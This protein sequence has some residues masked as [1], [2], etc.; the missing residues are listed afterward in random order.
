[1]S[2]TQNVVLRVTRSRAFFLVCTLAGAFVSLVAQGAEA[3]PAP[4]S[5]GRFIRALYEVIPGRTSEQVRAV[6]GDPDLV[7]AATRRDSASQVAHVWL[8]GAKE[9]ADLPTLGRVYFTARDRVHSTVGLGP[10]PDP[11]A[12]EE[13]TLDELMRALNADRLAM[14]RR[15][16]PRAMIRA[17]DRLRPLTERQQQTALREFVRVLSND[18][19][20]ASSGLFHGLL[21][22]MFEPKPTKAPI[23]FD[24]PGDPFERALLE[25]QREDFPS[26][27]FVFVETIPLLAQEWAI[28]AERRQ[29]LSL[30]R[31][32]ETYFHVSVAR[33]TP[34]ARP[35]ELLDAL[36]ESPLFVGADA[37]LNGPI[38]ILDP[39]RR[40]HTASKVARQLLQLVASDF[41]PD[42]ATLADLKSSDRQRLL[43]GIDSVRRSL[44][45]RQWHWDDE[46]AEYRVR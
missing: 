40:D 24:L 10:R 31:L 4:R 25:Q 9:A 20:P 32:R 12:F 45:E 15:Y 5:R 30:F 35:E 28:S 2:V 18:E 34:P 17:L 8:Y 6:L 14:S 43:R 22:L 13:R 29:L 42:A 36:V 41:Q 37:P 11:D 19:L 46:Q 26:L 1:M 21:T 44:S 7:V 33:V 39:R 23:P 16:D 3:T 27:P 38:F